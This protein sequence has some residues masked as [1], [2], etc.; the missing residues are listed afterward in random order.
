MMRDWRSLC[1]PCL[2]FEEAENVAEESLSLIGA[3]LLQTT[4]GSMA[5]LGFNTPNIHGAYFPL[6][7]L[8]EIQRGDLFTF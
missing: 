4:K 2:N 7:P 6:R 1:F 5:I 3:P 8:Q